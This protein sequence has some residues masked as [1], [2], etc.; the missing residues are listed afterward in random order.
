MEQLSNIET[1]V[2]KLMQLIHEKKEIST[3]DAAKKLGVSKVV[4]Q[5]WAD[6]LQEEKAIDIDYKL[7]NTLLKE[8]T[9]TEDELD[10]K[11][12]QIGSIKDAFVRK[13]ETMLTSIESDMQ[14]FDKLKSGF[15]DLK[16]E[17]GKEL[18]KVKDDLSELETYQ[19]LKKNIDQDILNQQA[20]YRNTLSQ[21][22][23]ELLEE[24]ER[25]KKTIDAVGAEKEIVKK[26]EEELSNLKSEEDKL[27]GKLTEIKKVIVNIENTIVQ[28]REK[29]DFTKQH[30]QK[31]EEVAG[32]IE[33]NISEKQKNLEPLFEKSKM[34][35]Q[36][37]LKLQNDLLEKV[38]QKKMEIT[39][40]AEE[41]KKAADKLKEFFDK[42]GKIESMITNIDKQKKE[43]E[44]ELTRLIKKVQ[45]YSTLSKKS[46]SNE[47]I[48]EI[49]K[50]VE[51]IE[52]KK[53]GMESQLKELGQSMQKQK[54]G[55]A[56]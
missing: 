27:S 23:K 1:G 44:V 20:E 25:Y 50:S 26:E 10:K 32:K 37:I 22:H 53:L 28:D 56:I 3:S 42:Q 55:E 36:K 41:S 35:E 12:Q 14:G 48:K 49:K 51:E 47:E 18:E 13:A 45:V 30:I 8:K 2:D 34:H 46:V 40:Q 38:R 9:I 39:S 21:I 5:E 29:I 7:T 15:L 52:K 4:I 11:G 54:S 24:S 6:F 16:K 43:L 19:N 31:L 17:L 33:K